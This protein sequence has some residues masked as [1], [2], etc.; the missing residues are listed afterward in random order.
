MSFLGVLAI[1]I[2][3]LSR[4]RASS[5][6][7]SR[8]CSISLRDYRKSHGKN[9]VRTRRRQGEYEVL[10]HESNQHGQRHSP[11]LKGSVRLSTLA[12]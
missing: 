6:F 12:T 7:L 5:S 1:I 9:K 4:S 2:G 10:I 11:L 3:A 8:F